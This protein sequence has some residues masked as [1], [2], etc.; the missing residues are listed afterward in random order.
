MSRSR[1]AVFDC[2]FVEWLC[3]KL[4]H[5][6]VFPLFAV[7]CSVVL[8]VWS[9]VALA[10]VYATCDAMSMAWVVLGLLNAVGNIVMAVFI[11]FKFMTPDK[12]LEHAYQLFR[13]G[14]G[15]LTYGIFIVW[16][17][18]WMVV[19]GQARNQSEANS[20]SNGQSTAPSATTSDGAD[21]DGCRRHLNVQLSIFTVYFCV[22]GALAVLTWIRWRSVH[23]YQNFVTAEEREEQ[24]K[25]A[26]ELQEKEEAERARREKQNAVPLKAEVLLAMHAT[27]DAART[28]LSPHPAER[29]RSTVVDP[30]PAA[31]DAKTGNRVV[32]LSP[33]AQKYAKEV[34]A[35]A[36]HRNGDGDELERWARSITPDELSET[37][38]PAAVARAAREIAREQRAARRASTNDATFTL[39]FESGD[40]RGE[41]APG[42]AVLPQLP[43]MPV[44]VGAVGDGSDDDGDVADGR[45]DRPAQLRLSI[46][47]GA[48]SPPMLSPSQKPL[49]SPAALGLDANHNGSSTGE[50]PLGRGPRQQTI[51][52]G[53]FSI[54]SANTPR[55]STAA[56]ASVNPVRR[57]PTGRRIAKSTTPKAKSRPS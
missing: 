39:E 19:A 9:S 6:P 23:R 30:P 29:W 43:P 51:D 17:I 25:R 42:A 33:A 1:H 41:P 55:S 56:G 40:E 2:E 44:M 31:P 50:L 45:P 20:E 35:A 26:K 4:R 37:A 15:K 7:V 14:W 13:P 5:T 11:Y 18:V 46:S 48:V 24:R 28:G 47:T 38:D 32:Q 57:D 3:P 36:A 10:A 34:A 8:I 12:S 27:H 21:D 49:N 54:A 53:S 22:G 52:S 16:L